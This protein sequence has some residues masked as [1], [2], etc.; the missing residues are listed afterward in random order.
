MIRASSM[1]GHRLA[2]TEQLCGQ[3]LRLVNPL[4]RHDGWQRP[5]GEE[6]LEGGGRRVAG[7]IPELSAQPG[8]VDDAPMAEEAD[9]YRREVHHAAAPDEAHDSADRRRRDR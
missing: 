7:L 6:C 5:P 3:P 2:R 1:V 9:L 4:R 8:R